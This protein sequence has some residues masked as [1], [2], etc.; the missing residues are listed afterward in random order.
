MNQYYLYSYC[1]LSVTH[2]SPVCNMEI[3]DCPYTAGLSPFVQTSP[4]E[5]QTPTL[6]HRASLHWPLNTQ[7]KCHFLRETFVGTAQVTMFLSSHISG[8]VHPE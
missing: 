3:T 5:L 2:C 4:G 7:P 6:L 8:L 1:D